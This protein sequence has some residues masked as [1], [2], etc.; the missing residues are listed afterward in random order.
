MRLIALVRSVLEAEISIR[1]LFTAPTVAGVARVIDATDDG[2][3]VPLARRERPE[4]LPRPSPST[5]CGC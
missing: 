4:R 2:S 3:R 1:D 5:G